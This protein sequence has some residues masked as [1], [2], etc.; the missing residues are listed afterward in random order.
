MFK[1]TITFT[2]YNG[3]KRSQDIYFN[4]SKPEILEME[5]SH[6]EGMSKYLENIEN[7]DRAA[8]EFA[9]ELISKSYGI[10]SE[11][12]LRFVK[13]KEISDEFEQSII[14]DAFFT[15]L[16][17]D[18]DYTQS[19]IFS[20]IPRDI[21]SEVENNNEL[22]DKYKKRL[23]ELKENKERFSDSVISE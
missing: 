12:G 5:Y 17:T 6:P 9:K 1:D 18:K 7:D 22:N 3:N 14:Y 2:D 11:D 4:L 13:S 20:V 23:E 19:F 21:A 8:Y 10:K 15:K 16:L